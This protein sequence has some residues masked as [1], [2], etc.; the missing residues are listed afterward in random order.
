MT[1]MTPPEFTRSGRWV[2][3]PPMILRPDDALGV[4]HRYSAFA[5]FHEDD[6]RDHRDHQHDQQQHGRN[7]ER[8][9]SLGLRL[10]VQIGD[11]SRQADY[12]AGKDQQRHAVAHAAL[13]D[14][15]AQ[16]HDEDAAG[17]KR[18]HGHQHK[19]RCPGL[20]HEVA[21]GAAA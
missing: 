2:D 6:E 9:P 17:G 14:L 3:C 5:A 8:A 7:G 10:F 19:T 12:D 15:L 21:L 13:G 1:G 18:Q 4:L 16:P 11:A 20:T